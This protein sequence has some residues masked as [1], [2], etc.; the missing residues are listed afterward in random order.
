GR[1]AGRAADFSTQ[2]PTSC[3]VSRAAAP[4][5]LPAAGALVRRCVRPSYRL[6]LM[7]AGQPCLLWRSGPAAGV[8]ALGE[9]A[10]EPGPDA[11]VDVRW[12]PLPAPLPRALLRA[13]PL[14]AGAEVLRMPAGS[15][16]SYLAPAQWRRLLEV[17]EDELGPAPWAGAGPAGERATG[18]EPA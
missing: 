16:P 1:A 10:G 12:R 11:A 13:D 9:L 6:D 7:V 18:I 2:H 8:H 14:L 3:G 4:V 17:L 5:P 15:N